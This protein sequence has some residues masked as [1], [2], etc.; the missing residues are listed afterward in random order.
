[1]YIPVNPMEKASCWRSI[2]NLKVSEF[3]EDCIMVGNFN[4]VGNNVEKRGGI[5]GRDPLSDKMEELIDEWD[6]LDV[7]PQRG[8]FTW[9]NMRSRS[10]HIDVCLD[11]FIDHCNFL[12]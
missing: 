8:K 7:N 4:V 5:Y 9:S 11:R 2:L 6:M 10:R 12:H 1:M 3:F